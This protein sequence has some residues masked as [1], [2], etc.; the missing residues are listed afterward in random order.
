MDRHSSCEIGG[1]PGC[2]YFMFNGQCNIGHE[3][4]Y[5][6]KQRLASLPPEVANIKYDDLLK[7]FVALV[8]KVQQLTGL[9]Q[10]LRNELALAMKG[11]PGKGDRI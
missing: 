6:E 3:T 11:K 8:D 10:Q 5:G 7:S 9:T 1:C 4:D 2:I